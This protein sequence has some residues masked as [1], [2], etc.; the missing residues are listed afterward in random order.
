MKFTVTIGLIF[1][2]LLAWLVCA[3]CERLEAG[4]GQVEP[5]SLTGEAV[6]EEIEANVSAYCPCKRCCGKEPSHPA[7]RVT[8]SGYKIKNGDR[9]VA[10]PK[11]YPFGTW[12]IIEG[13]NDSKPVK[14]L[15]R[16]GAIDETN[17]FDILFAERTDDKYNHQQALNWGRKQMTVKVLRVE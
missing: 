4:E 16:G 5:S 1:I 13:Y 3:A 15:D 6:L 2:A 17:E 12:L 11:E 7:Y 14:V 8:T 10:A 9:L